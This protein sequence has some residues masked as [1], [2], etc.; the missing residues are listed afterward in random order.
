[1]TKSE[2]L[3][4]DLV[5]QNKISFNEADLKAEKNQAKR[6]L[7]YMLGAYKGKMISK[8]DLYIFGIR[9]CKKLIDKGI[10]PDFYHVITVVYSQERQNFMTIMNRDPLDLF[11][12]INS[13]WMKKAMLRH[14]N[15]WKN[16]DRGKKVFISG[17]GSFDIEEAYIRQ[18]ADSPY[19]TYT[20]LPPIGDLRCSGYFPNENNDY[21]VR[22]L[23]KHSIDL[24]RWFY[25]HEFPIALVDEVKDLDVLGLFNFRMST[26]VVNARIRDM[27]ERKLGLD[28]EDKHVFEYPDNIINFAN[29]NG[30]TVPKNGIELKKQAKIF[31]NCSGGY[32]TSIRKKKTYIIYNEEEMIEIS[33]KGKIRQHFGKRNSRIN[34]NRM[35]QV[36]KLVEKYYTNK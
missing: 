36:E 18:V 14:L 29:E 24:F 6:K 5:K 3:L 30:F 11:K 32:V 2:E 25:V 33:P 34:R 13:V 10:E 9:A 1:M 7:L 22:A 17:M 28:W 12:R 27:R 8:D 21:L 15:T 20:I 26:A 16:I 31:S 35:V 4:L 19:V 23:Y